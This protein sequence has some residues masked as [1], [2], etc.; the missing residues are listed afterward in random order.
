MLHRPRS[1]VLGETALSSRD[2]I[3]EAQALVQDLTDLELEF[4]RH[5]TA[6]ESQ[7]AIASRLQLEEEMALAVRELLL[8]KLGA[9][10]T[11]DAVRVGIYAG[12]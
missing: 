10:V 8:K 4:L 3:S 11:A 2:R 6:G 1:E 9:A 12:L 5:L 7:V